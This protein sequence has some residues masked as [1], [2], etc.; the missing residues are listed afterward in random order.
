MKKIRDLITH[1]SLFI[2][3]LSFLLLIPAI[4]GYKGTRINYDI[5]VY[6]PEDV[7][8]IK[9]ENILTDEFGIGSYA[10]LIVDNISNYDMLKLEDKIK[11]IDGVNQVGSI[12]DVLDTTIPLDILPDDLRNKIDKDGSTLILVTLKGGASEDSSINA[13]KDLR[14]VV[15]EQK[16]SSMTAMVLDTMN[17]SNKE[18]LLYVV[19]AV[20]FCLIVLL[21]T[22]NSYLIPIFLLLNIGIAIIYN[23]GSNV[24]LGEISYITKAITAIL[25]LGVTMDFS[26]FL[27]HKYELYKEK[28]LEKKE[29]MSNALKDTFKSVI[30]SSLTTVAGF[31]ALVTMNLTLGRDIGI[32]MAKGVIC[33]LITVFTLF[34]SLLLVFDK[35]IENT[36]HK[37]IFPKFER[38]QNFSVKHHILI[39]I[40]FVILMI[41]AYIGNKNYKVYYK[42]DESLPS[43]LPFNIANETLKEK[44]NIVSPEIVLIDK[45]VKGEDIKNL[46]NE[47]KTLKGID[48]VLTPSSI[49]D[50]GLPEFMLPEGLVTL[51]NNDKYQLMLL[52]STY[53]I[54]SDE[55]NNEISEVQKIVKKYDKNAIVAGEGPLMKDL[56]EIADHDFKMVNYTSII[57][58]FIIMLFVLK[59]I[60]L[61]IILIFA[62]EFAIFV[63]LAISFYTGV[64]LPFI[65]SIIVGTIQL[66]ATIDYA[67][68]MSTKYLEEREKT[69]DK[70]KAIKDTLSVT[71]PSIIV[72]SLCFFAA[73]IGVSIYTKID[74][75]GSICTLLSRGALISMLVVIL[76][77]PSLLLICDKFIMKTTM[78]GNNMKKGLKMFMI[79]LLFIP[80]TTSALTKKETV[81][82]NLDYNGSVKNTIVVNHLYNNETKTLEDE[83]ELTDILNLNGKETF[84]IENNK[85]NWNTLGNDIF[86]R[87]TTKK[88]LPIDT[89]ITYYLNDKKM[90]VNDM[91]GKKGSIKIVLSFKNNV[92]NLVKINNNMENLF[93]PF[94]V[95]AGTILDSNSKNINVKNGKV[96]NTGTRSMVVGIASPG[97]YESIKLDSLKELDDI[98]ITY[99]TTKFSLNNIYIATTPK[100]LEEKDLEIFDKLDSI[101]G[102][103]NSLKSNMDLIEN[104]VKELEDGTNTLSIGSNTITTKLKEVLD[105]LYQI[106]NGSIKLDSGIETAIN[107]LNEITSSIDLN[108]T[109][110][111]L[112]TLKSGNN[113]A[114]DKL[115]KT[116][117]SINERI[118]NVCPLCDL[119]KLNND[120]WNNIDSVELL[121]AKATYEGNLSIIGLLTKNNEAITS[122]L[123]MISKIPNVATQLTNGLI[124][125]KNGSNSLKDGTATLYKG[126]NELYLGM[127]NLNQGIMK[128]NDG[129]KKLNNGVNEFNNKGITTLYNYSLKINNYTN[130]LE[131]LLNL[132]KEYKGYTSTNVDSTLFISMVK[133]AK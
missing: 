95:T 80:L 117:K 118:V 18:I 65:A 110:T 99:D 23:L 19:I 85:I 120:I 122:M 121:N 32:V 27:Y 128:L 22:T 70:Y 53:E 127:Q 79:S 26:I 59:S 115:T 132:D 10:F 96:V 6:L 58:I 104:S 39:L 101:Y 54:A 72:S 88:L 20:I 2:V 102:N 105:G 30:G 51:M 94:I 16:V 49:L 56:V 47:L 35:Q 126:V 83:T 17:L 131:A 114:I 133:S 124:E 8:T 112:N 60:G 1:H 48:L 125:L 111:D 40:I 33:G 67:I 9:G 11:K 25:Q 4:I 55:L 116:N 100:L 129:T 108:K 76:I 13:I 31:L 97:L 50:F 92:P 37:N 43:N 3:I 103:V 113:T 73:T 46:N 62:I 34:P 12:A 91:V 109:V 28:K 41:P 75:I 24:F 98:V 5:L 57:V 86:Y 45:N 93:T 61:P 21:I 66:G 42:L 69:S 90:E 84:K 119:T 68:L 29:A 106:E 71:V 107:K 36:K 82:S 15:D 87:G 52:N 7:D 38:L 74:M 123:N 78:K 81:Y 89:K 64:R 44:F 77:L 63:N 130:K 14:K